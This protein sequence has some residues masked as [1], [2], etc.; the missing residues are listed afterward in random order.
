MPAPKKRSK[1]LYQI[2]LHRH[3]PSDLTW[4]ITP[5]GEKPVSPEVL[6][7]ALKDA[8]I[9]E[10]D[11]P[12]SPPRDQNDE[13]EAN[14]G[15]MTGDTNRQKADIQME[16]NE[17]IN[18]QYMVV[19]AAKKEKHKYHKGSYKS[20]KKKGRSIPAA[21]R[22]KVLLRDGCTCQAPGCGKKIFLTIHHLIAFAL[23]GI[24]NIAFM[25]TLCSSC[26]AL[27]H[28]GKLSVEGEVPNRLIW[29][30]G[31]GRII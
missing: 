23:C 30:D 2:V 11:E 6:E 28:E 3:L 31:K 26:H 4:C 18:E 27:I 5:K 19:K 25:V 7:K 9:V 15:V 10:L 22:K 21:L 29:R 1:P 8:E 16:A 13:K 24:H 14:S 20:S 17:Y 12:A